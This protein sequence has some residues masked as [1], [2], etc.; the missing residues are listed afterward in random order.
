[1][2]ER[3]FYLHQRI[4]QNGAW[5]SAGV[6]FRRPTDEL[7]HPE[8]WRSTK[9][10]AAAMRLRPAMQQFLPTAKSVLL[11]VALAFMAAL[12][13]EVILPLLLA[14]EAGPTS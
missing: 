8:R 1:M 6:A 14:A 2:I 10:P 13:I 7:V 3:M 5:H 9:H 4:A 12:L 11:P